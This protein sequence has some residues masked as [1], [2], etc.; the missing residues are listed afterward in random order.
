MIDENLALVSVELRS[1]AY[2]H[3]GG[4]AFWPRSC[5]EQVFR[6]LAHKNRVILGFDIV[7]LWPS[8]DGLAPEIGGGSTYD[9]GSDMRTR[10]W[11]EAVGLSLQLALHD[12]DQLTLSSS[13]D[14]DSWFAVVATDRESWCEL[15]SKFVVADVQRKM[16]TDE[17]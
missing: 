17:G 9:M 7:T 10:S 14:S 5:I 11:D 12:L 2:V 13:A 8:A 1:E 6:E 15:N 4:E 3:R 16:K